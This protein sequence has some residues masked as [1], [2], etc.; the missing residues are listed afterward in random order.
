MKVLVTGANGHVG[1]NLVPALVARGHHVR[2]SIRDLGDAG[3]AAPLA[4]MGA[5][6]VGLDIRRQDQFD[7][8]A[9]GVE[10]MF[11]VAATYAYH[12]KSADEIIRD[13]VEGAEA[14]I[15]AAAKAGVGKVVLTSSVV[16]LPLVAP[17]E[18]P[19]NET[20]WQTA[21]RAPYVV[22]KTEAEKRAWTLA[23]ELGVHLVTVLPGAVGGPGFARRTPTI[24]VVEG[25]MLGTMRFGTPA[26]NFPW[27][28]IRDV[29]AGHVLA[30]EKPVSGRFILASD[31]SP[32]FR[33]MI[34][35]MRRVD[36]TIPKAGGTVPESLERLIP[37]FDWL[38]SVT[39]G[40]PRVMTAELA[41]TLKG[42]RWAPSN[43]RAKA[44]LGWRPAVPLARSLADTML[45]IRALRRA[46][47]KSRMA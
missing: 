9:E 18:L 19:V 25:I 13:S 47:G 20:R 10:L 22:A 31:V 42:R 21:S 45:A 17:G 8:A 6:V 24:D 28:D 38:S 23:E 40:S 27:V 34:T 32:G 16:T 3:K 1:G 46:E 41:A 29:V 37:F 33:E 7:R 11:H 39:S 4:A 35:A 5:E 12:G 14:A 43:A 30:G 26:A 44:E 36:P 2:A 15:R